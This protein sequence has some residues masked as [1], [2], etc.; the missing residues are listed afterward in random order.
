MHI[1]ASGDDDTVIT[2]VWFQNAVT[3]GC[4]TV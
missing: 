3:D 4:E 2:R 1:I